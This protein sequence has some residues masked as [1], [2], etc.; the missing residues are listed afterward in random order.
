MPV[1]LFVHELVFAEIEAEHLMTAFVTETMPYACKI[2][3]L[4]TYVLALYQLRLY[5]DVLNDV[6]DAVADGECDR[7]NAGGSVSIHDM[8]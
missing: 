3:V 7:R 2:S 6:L 5:L 8:Y 4:L 1:Y